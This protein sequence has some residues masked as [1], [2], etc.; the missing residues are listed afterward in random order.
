MNL[1]EGERWFLQLD[2]HHRF[3]Q[4]WDVKLL[5][6]A[7]ATGS[8]KPILTAYA[9]G[10]YVPDDPGSFTE[11]PM[12]MEFDR[13]T[14]DGL[15]LFRP[16][17]IPD[18]RTKTDPRRSR[19]VS[20][21]FLFAPGNFVSDVPYDPSLYFIGEEITLTVRAFTH[22]YDLYHPGE[23]ILW[24]EYTRNYRSKHW[25]DHT[26]DRGAAVDWAE[27]D[28][29]SRERP[30]MLLTS[31]VRGCLAWGQSGPSP[32]MRRSPESASPTGGPRTTPGT[33]LSHPTRQPTTT[34]GQS[35]PKTTLCESL[36]L[37]RS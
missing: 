31:R 37:P 30:A 18:W 36:C 22:G 9:T 27:R 8:R 19:F 5:K 29:P 21:H 25:D 24:H 17:A 6:Q 33:I 23:V 11:E 3:V 35:G 16:G 10:P 1:W 7:A 12:Q 15:V 2:S 26:A 28:V 34:T 32:T 4:G 20:A 13:F 14:E